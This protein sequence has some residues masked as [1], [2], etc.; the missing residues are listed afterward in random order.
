M[1]RNYSAI[2]D[3]PDVPLEQQ[4]PQGYYNQLYGLVGLGIDNY[5]V[6][7]G[8][9]AKLRE[10]SV[11][12]RF[13]RAQLA[14]VPFLRAFDGIAISLIGRNL[15]TFTDYASYDPE[16][17]ESGG[18]VGSAAVARVDGYNYPNFRTFTAALEVNF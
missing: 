7:D 8:S 5:F 18:E 2:Q 14:S 1:F 12:Y 10:V 11:R 6:Q 17:G 3:Q 16:T 9:F 4:K 13:D 15:L